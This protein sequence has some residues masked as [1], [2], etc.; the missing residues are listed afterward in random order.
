MSPTAVKVCATVSEV[1][2]GTYKEQ[3]RQDF[4]GAGGPRVMLLLDLRKS[5]VEFNV[6]ATP[7]APA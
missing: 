4:A 7:E 3:T 5:Q 6:H 1:C 2:W